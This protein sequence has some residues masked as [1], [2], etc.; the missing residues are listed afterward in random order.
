MPQN[1]NDVN[2]TTELTTEGTRQR[3][4]EPTAARRE[5]VIKIGAEINEIE[6]RKPREKINESE[7]C[8]F[9]KISELANSELDGLRN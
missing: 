8:F 7:S 9:E 2:P 5:E 6:K 3:T 1:K 4:N